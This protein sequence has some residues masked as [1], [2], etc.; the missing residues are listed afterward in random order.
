MEKPSASPATRVRERGFTLIELITVMA[1]M[2]V[3]V[4]I[5]LPNYKISI[6]MAKEAVLME[7]LT[8]LRHLVV[9][10][11]SDKGYFPPTLQAL[12]DEGYLKRIPIDPITTN[13]DWEVVYSEPDPSNP[14]AVP[15]VEWVK[16][17]APGTSIGPPRTPY[18]EW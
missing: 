11:E 5:A 16:S 2:A 17:N 12:V 4:G 6:I 13:A 7:N 9:Q 18:S 3:L 14:T 10:Y 1:I 8:T 15:G